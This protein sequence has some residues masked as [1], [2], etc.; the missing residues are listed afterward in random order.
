LQSDVLAPVRGRPPLGRL[1]PLW[2]ARTAAENQHGHQR[3]DLPVRDVPPGR[4]Q[5]ALTAAATRLLASAWAVIRRPV[6][7]SEA[8]DL[9]LPSQKQIPRRCAP[10]DDN[11]THAIR[12][13][14]S[15]L[16]TTFPPTTLT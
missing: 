10:R 6:I 9:L 16:S 5:P 2:P 1:P 11:G 15:T 12:S 14:S 13:G 7:P 4:M 8:R 3:E